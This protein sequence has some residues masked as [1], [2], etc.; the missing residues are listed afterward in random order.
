MDNAKNPQDTVLS[1]DSGD[2]G[3]RQEI[4]VLRMTNQMLWALLA[5]IF[6]KMQVSST[7]IKASVSS[8]LGYDIVL[9]ASAQHELLEV[10]EDSSD[11]VSKSIMLLTFVSQMESDSFAVNVE[12]VEI[13]EVIST[14][15]GVIAKNNPELVLDLDIH[16]AGKSICMDYDYLSIALVMLCELI[17]VTQQPATPLKITTTEAED[18]WRIDIG[19]V[20]QVVLDTLLSVSANGPEALLKEAQLLPIRKLQ[21]YVAFKIL[22][23]LSIQ[24]SA[25]LEPGLDKPTYIRLMMPVASISDGALNCE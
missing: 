1:N 24:V 11:Q 22:E 9:G 18:R 3:N 4:E 25:L 14:V 21:F 15:V 7:A 6:K 12:P 13:S 23:H 5:D 20:S 17:A 2:G 10:I 8:L 19:V 16:A